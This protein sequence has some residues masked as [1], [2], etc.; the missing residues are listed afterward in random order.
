M[1]LA[2]MALLINSEPEVSL[3][4]T[5][6][7]LAHYFCVADLVEHRGRTSA[8]EKRDNVLIDAALK[9][10][11]PMR[12]AAVAEFREMVLREQE[13]L[14]VIK[15]KSDDEVTAYVEHGFDAS[16]RSQL[17]KILAR[18]RQENDASN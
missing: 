8:D 1:I 11:A 15:G 2:F 12:P 6:N 5:P 18:T 17:K 16:L 14:E 9:S 7:L 10:C 3:Q 13:T 4:Q